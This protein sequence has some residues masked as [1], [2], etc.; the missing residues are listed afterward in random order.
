MRQCTHTLPH[1]SIANLGTIPPI[2]Y[3]PAQ[4]TSYPENKQWWRGV[5]EGA[6]EEVRDSARRA[7]IPSDRTYQAH[8]AGAHTNR[9][10]GGTGGVC[11]RRKAECL[12]QG[13][14][15]RAYVRIVGTASQ[16]LPEVAKVAEE[17]RVD[18]EFDYN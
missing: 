8:A 3:P 2:V 9:A 10:G 13:A 17:P 1:Q 5:R 16:T 11:A 15:P 4:V 14:F 12:M 6:E 18:D 7:R